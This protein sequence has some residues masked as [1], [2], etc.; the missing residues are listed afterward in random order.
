MLALGAG[1]RGRSAARPL[2]VLQCLLLAACMLCGWRAQPVVDATAPWVL[3]TGVM[4]A[5]AM[6]VQN[7]A[8]RLAFGAL[9][10]TTVMTGNV[11]Q[12]VIDVVDLT[13]GAADDAVRSRIQKF[14]WPVVAF[15]AGA[16][17]GAFAYL[18]AAFWAL[19]LPV[20]ILCGL[21]AWH[22]ADVAPSPPARQGAMT[23]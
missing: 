15:G 9:T 7:A 4:G 18:Q 14:L 17:C 21:A 12:L 3:G 1:R 16:I 2:L 8:S 5:A 22:A 20:A 10:P 6:G 13:R 19:A 11:T 23:D